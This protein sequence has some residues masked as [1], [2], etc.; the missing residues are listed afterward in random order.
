[1]ATNWAEW[2]NPVI[3]DLKVGEGYKAIIGV[4]YICNKGSWGT[5]D[6]FVFE[7]VSD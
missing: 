7:K 3:P 4:H 5:I 1:M 6:D 2:K